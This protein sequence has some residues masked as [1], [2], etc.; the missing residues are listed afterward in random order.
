MTRRT[1]L[2]LVAAAGATVGASLLA[3]CQPATPAAPT[4]APPKPTTAPAS[5]RTAAPAA[6]PTTAPAAAPTTAPAAKPTAAQPAAAGSPTRGGRI[7]AGQPVDITSLNPVLGFDVFSQNVWSMFYLP[8]LR[9]NPDTGELEP[10]LAE[11]FGP[12]SDGQGVTFTLR[13]GLTWSDG[14]PF[15]GEDYRYTIEA[16]GRSKRFPRRGAFQSVQGFAEYADGKADNISGI[17]VS[18]GGKTI[19]VKLVRPFCPSMTILS[20]AAVPANLGILPKHH[21]VKAWDNKTTD[22]STSIDDHPLN[23]A[24]PASMGPFVFKEFTPGVQVSMTRNDRY[25]RGAPF[26]EEFIAK[27]YADNVAIK[28]ALL[29]GE[30]TFGFGIINPADVEEVQKVGA[31]T[32]NLNRQPSSGNLFFIAWD[33]KSEKAPWLAVKEVRQALW[34]GLDVKAIVD[35]VRLG[36][37]QRVLGP[38]MQGSWAYPEGGLNSYDYNPTRSKQL[39]EGAGA[40]MGPDGIYL[41][42]NGQPMQMRIVSFPPFKTDVEIAQEQYR[43]IG[44]QIDP[45]IGTL[46]AMFQHFDAANF[47]KEGVMSGSDFTN[48]DPDANYGAWHSS[49]AG[50]GGNNR[51]HYSNPEVDRALDAGRSGPDCSTAGRKQAYWTAMRQINQDA[52]F[53]FTYAPDNLVAASKKIQGF[54]AKPFSPHSQHNIEKWWLMP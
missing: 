39:L 15:T 33:N 36:Y 54:E 22:T 17:T 13:D 35:K 29:G 5:A 14:Q 41:W 53:T 42:T 34:Y 45:V 32:L 16:L 6:K 49:Q 25:Y 28:S 10:G 27:V 38:I 40:K 31:A 18:D 3:A 4:A 2:Q 44:I 9:V 48:P 21:F 8:L 51:A 12:A 47:D 26:V 20:G 23:N 43:Q 1:L 11:K 19:T 46:Q 24:P 52:P 37:S 30:A 7:V 50:P